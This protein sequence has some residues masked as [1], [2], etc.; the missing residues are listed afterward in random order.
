MPSAG[1]CCGFLGERTNVSNARQSVGSADSIF[2]SYVALANGLVGDLSGIGL[3]DGSLKPAGESGE[4]NV[5]LFAKW[6]QS[7]H[8]TDFQERV[9]AARAGTATHWWAAIPIQQADGAL[10]GVFCASQ[11]LSTASPIWRRRIRWWRASARNGCT[12]CFSKPRLGA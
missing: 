8:W 12:G 7:L 6:V 1:L 2:T 10:L 9:P 4:L 11:R 3:L 5:A